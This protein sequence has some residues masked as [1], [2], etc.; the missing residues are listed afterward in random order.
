M[1]ANFRA[2]CPGLNAVIV[3]EVRVRKA[4]IVELDLLSDLC[5][6][7][8]AVWGYD[9]KFMDAC[10]SELTLHPQELVQTQ[11]AVA[12]DS[13][14]IIGMAQVLVKEDS[15]ELLKLFIEPESIGSGIGR[16]LFEWALQATRARGAKQM[17][18]E[19]DPG[20]ADFYRKMGARDAGTASSESIAG[21]FLP[22]LVYDLR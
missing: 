11:I 16:L 14:N 13:G 7:S 1:R 4:R 18:M 5:M 22:K 19:A 10:R 12:E 8:K 9:K 20:A 17:T 3:I 15:S 2:Q 21:R 6:R